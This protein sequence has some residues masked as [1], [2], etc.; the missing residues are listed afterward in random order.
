[1]QSVLP[2]DQPLNYALSSR[3]SIL[4]LVYLSWKFNRPDWLLMGRASARAPITGPVLAGR[5][6]THPVC[7]FFRKSNYRLAQ[8]Y[9]QKCFSAKCKCDEAN[10]MRM[11][12]I[13]KKVAKCGQDLWDMSHLAR[14]GARCCSGGKEELNLRSPAMEFMICSSGWMQTQSDTAAWREWS[15]QWTR[16]SANSI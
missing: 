9:E 15:A 6:L 1:M 14:D 10:G 11:R 2:T 4:I 8:I 3:Q 12:K 5:T 16:S 13:Y 7:G